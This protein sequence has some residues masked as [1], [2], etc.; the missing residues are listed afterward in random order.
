[1]FPMRERERERERER[2]HCKQC[3][4]SLIKHGRKIAIVGWFLKH[5]SNERERARERCHCKLCPLSLIKQRKKSNKLLSF[6]PNF[7]AS[8]LKIQN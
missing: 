2:C 6:S 8:K 4:L 1:M 5:V 3:P 7:L